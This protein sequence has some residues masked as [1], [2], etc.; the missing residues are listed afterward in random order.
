MMNIIINSVTGLI[1]TYINL[2]KKNKISLIEIA[3]NVQIEERSLWE[4]LIEDNT[5]P[6]CK[7]TPIELLE[8]SSGG[9]CTNF[10]CVG[11]GA[12]FNITALVKYAER[13]GSN[14]LEL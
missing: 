4:L 2:F 6:D 7:V 11:C 14:E 1:Y 12:L 8:G 3:G 13:V 9:M 10:K 5:C